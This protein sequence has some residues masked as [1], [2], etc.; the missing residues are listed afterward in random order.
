[1]AVRR[2]KKTATYR[3]GTIKKGSDTASPEWL[4]MPQ[5]FRGS[6]L[7]TYDV[8]TI[9]DFFILN[10][11]SLTPEKTFY[12][13][14]VLADGD[15]TYIGEGRPQPRKVQNT[16]APALPQ[17]FTGMHGMDMKTI[18]S[19]YEAQLSQLRKINDQLLERLDDRDNTIADLQTRLSEAQARATTLQIQFDQYKEM[20]TE[21]QGLSDKYTEQ[22][23]RLETRYAKQANN[24]MSG[25][26][27]WMPMILQVI[28]M[29]RGGGAPTAPATIVPPTGPAT[30][31]AVNGITAPPQS[32]G[33]ENAEPEF[34]EV[35]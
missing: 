11:F 29:L 32:A 14:E 34:A 21:L 33:N 19:A 23:H 2:F 22:V 35:G 12:V 10:P 18:T 4:N 9:D 3:V 25:L 24:G 13:Y 7:A 26:E 6:E 30:P 8:T 5:S 28:S 16:D 15:L 31:V 1:M 27:S 17:S 20:R